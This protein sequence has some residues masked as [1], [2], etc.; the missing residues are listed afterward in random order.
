MVSEN[1][2]CDE[3]L[4]LSG[5][6]E[7]IRQMELAISGGKHWYI[8]LLEAIGRWTP[9]YENLDGRSYR[10]LIH[11]EAFDWLLLAERICLALENLVPEN[12]KETLLFYGKPPLDIPAAQFKEL[13]GDIKYHQYLNYFYGVTVE[14]AL[15]QAVVEEIRKERW[16]SGHHKDRDNTNE[17]YKR[18]YGTTRA[19]MLTCFRDEMGYDQRDSISLSELKEFTY[20]AFKHRLKQ[21]DKAKVA[22]DTRKA[23]EW[24]KR[25]GFSRWL[26]KH[27]IALEETEV[28]PFTRGR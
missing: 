6:N 28:I 7:V 5:V 18:I 27:D 2:N 8:A 23:L 9:V 3:R 15:Q 1:E 4:T 16:A 20:W 12:E 11:G 17:A 14:E 26:D 10:Y 13:I 22:S 25:R 24:L 19:A 21:C